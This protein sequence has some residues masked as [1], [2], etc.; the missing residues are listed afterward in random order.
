MAAKGGKTRINQ[1][2]IKKSQQTKLSK[3]LP[4]TQER[5][6][7]DVLVSVGSVK[8]YFIDLRRLFD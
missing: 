3:E 2:A 5:L 7:D 4:G 6:S 8:I 1:E